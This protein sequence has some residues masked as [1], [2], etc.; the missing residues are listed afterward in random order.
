MAQRLDGKAVAASIKEDLALRVD[1]LKRKGV[2]PGL[3]TILVGDDVGSRKYVAGKHRDCAE[4]GI[5]SIGI[6]LPGDAG[7]ADIIAAVERLNADPK[8]TGYIVQL[9]LPKGVDEQ[10]VIEHVDPRKDA[11]GMHPYNL[12]ELVLHIDGRLSTP[13]PCTPRG[14]IALLGHYG[15]DLNGKDICV[16][17]RG[18]TIGRTIGLMLTARN[19]NATVTLCHTGT[20][21]VAEHLRRADVVVAAAG[22]AGFV[23]PGDIKQGAVLVDV[24]VSRVYDEQE[25]RWRVKGDID[26]GCYEIASAYTPNPGGVGPMTRAMLLAN[27]VETAERAAG[28]GEGAE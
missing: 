23:K 9:P 7:E 24:G 16:V 17:G 6:E 26:K 12:G 25:Q 28:L 15:I 14:V 10:R 5:Q 3:G 2:E 27:V 8:C 18:I 19:V 11:D 1:R 21:D 4:V 22:Q 13:L 20:R